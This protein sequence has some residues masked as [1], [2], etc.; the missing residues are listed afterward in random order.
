[1]AINLAKAV[2]PTASG[3]VFFQT[4]KCNYPDHPANLSM[5]GYFCQNDFQTS[6]KYSAF[7]PKLIN[8]NRIYCANGDDEKI[9]FSIVTKI[10]DVEGK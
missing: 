7:L 9:L 1:M 6:Y 2:I 5:G 3:K 8:L 4:P 10:E